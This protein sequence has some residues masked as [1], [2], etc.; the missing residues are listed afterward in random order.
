ME[1]FPAVE[2]WLRDKSNSKNTAKRERKFE[3]MKNYIIIHKM[4]LVYTMIA[5]ALIG[6]ACSLP[7]TQNETIGHV[8]SWTMPSGSSTDAM[9][10]LPW[11]DQTKLSVSENVNNGKTDYIYTLMLPGSTENEITQ[12][13]KD[14]KKILD[15]TSVKVFPLNENVKRPLYSAALHTFFRINIDAG[16]MSDEELAKQIESQ[17]KENGVNTSTIN[18]KTQNDGH[19]EIKLQLD[20]NDKTT[21]DFELRINDGNNKEMI[22]EKRNT[23][24][25]G[26]FNGKSDDEIRK[27]VKED[28][29]NPDIQDK[30]IQIIREG[31]GIKVQ[32]NKTD[33][34]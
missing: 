17:L 11:M 16:K 29:G 7:V 14:L 27:M 5:L 23:I 31:N 2:K 33:T 1:T 25:G 24:D 28:L 9:Y 4:K 34:K 19:R 26:R 6:G 15:I 30:D 3:R 20:Q 18:V 32:V 13:Q 12:Y 22:K 8:L 10:K 21:S